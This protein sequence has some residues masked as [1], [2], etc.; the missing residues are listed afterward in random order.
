MDRTV[1]RIQEQ[2]EKD[3]GF[4]A[5]VS[6]NYGPQYP[7]IVRNPFMEKQ[8]HELEWYFER[9]LEFPFTQKVRAREAAASIPGYGEILFKQ[10]FQDNPEIYA[11]Y[12][13][14]QKQNEDSQASHSHTYQK[15]YALEDIQPYKDEKAF[16][17][18]EGD[19]LLD[20][21]E[22]SRTADEDALFASLRS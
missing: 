18:F 13:A 12:K 7:I 2:A 21:G 11:E 10:V 4:S 14:L 1:I 6:F 5:T 9:H 3:E 20:H 8:E 17:F 15:Y 19:G 22:R 16:L